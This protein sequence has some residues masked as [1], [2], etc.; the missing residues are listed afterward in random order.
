MTD[1]LELPV[2]TLQ[3]RST[4]FGELAQGRVTLVVNVA[5][6]CGYTPQYAGL[7]ALYRELS[8]R[9]FGVIGFPCNQFGAQEPGT[10]PEIA[11]FC[12]ATFGFTFPM[13]EK[14]DVNGP[15]RDPVWSVLT[16]APYTAGEP[17]PDPE[18]DP[19]AR[20]GDVEWSFE[21]FLVTADGRVA[22]R[23]RAETE[24]DDHRL[25]AQVEALL[26]A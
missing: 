20:P 4:T 23:F 1:L 6:R 10:G 12:S 19:P 25:L 15:G 21:K 17:G 13:S 3:G 24:P 14:V 22:A 26:T 7:E 9:G 16:A 11:E 2:T 18:L 5:S 8:G